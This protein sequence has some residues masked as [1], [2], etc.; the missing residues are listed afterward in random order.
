MEDD[1]T[2]APR[3]DSLLPYD[4]WAQEAMRGVAIRALQFAGE[5]G[6][7][8]QHHFYVS[9]RTDHVGV[10]IPARLLAQYPEE[11]TIVLQHQFWDLI[12]NEA[13]GFFSVG[14]S[15]GG[16][17]STLVI[18][19]AALTAFADP[20]A[21]FGLRFRAAPVEAANS[22][23][24]EETVEEEVAEEPERPTEE[25]QVVSLDAFRK[26]RD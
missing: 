15:F 1:D 12:V 19:F 8:G 14:L 22:E 17:A 25:P 20:H 23:E 13:A 18:P 6:M 4:V 21:Q 10:T 26:R 9:F 16:I 24:L 2:P 7:P 5:Q 11:M 3:P